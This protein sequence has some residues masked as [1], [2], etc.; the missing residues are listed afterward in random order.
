MFF[1]PVGER[2]HFYFAQIESDHSGL[3]RY[4]K[5]PAR[6]SSRQAS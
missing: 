1:P 5:G 3:S 6:K 4:E 2:Y